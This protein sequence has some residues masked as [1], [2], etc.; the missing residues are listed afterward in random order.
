MKRERTDVNLD[1][2]MSFAPCVDGV[3]L[4]VKAV[5]VVHVRRTTHDDTVDG[6][7]GDRVETLA[8]EIQPLVL[9][10]RGVHFE[11][12]AVPP[13]GPA[14]PRRLALVE[15]AVGVD[16]Q[17][18]PRQVGVHAPGHDRGEDASAHRRRHGRQIPDRLEGPRACRDGLPDGDQSPA[19]L[20]SPAMNRTCPQNAGLCMLIRPCGDHTQLF[21]GVSGTFTYPPGSTVCCHCTRE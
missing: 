4:H 15:A 8:D 1:G 12:A 2:Q 11:D 16:A 17:A 18:R 3:V 7:P 19:P 6:H 14:D 5:R 9:A 13:V 21:S 20:S 10:Q